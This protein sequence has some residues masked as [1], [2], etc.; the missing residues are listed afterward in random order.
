LADERGKELCAVK[1]KSRAVVR[2]VS[3]INVSFG[4]D[5]ELCKL[6]VII[7]S[8][9]VQGAVLAEERGKELCAVKQKSR[10]GIRFVC[11]IDVSFRL[12]QNTC[13]FEVI[14]KSTPV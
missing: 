11:C 1:H 14:V 6:E 3:C 12:D 5:Q 13:N 7:L 4:L 2:F 8:T 9:V 10:A